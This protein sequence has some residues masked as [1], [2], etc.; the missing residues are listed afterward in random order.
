MAVGYLVPS[1]DYV[2][3]SAPFVATDG[4]APS[5][6]M[7]SSVNDLVKYAGFHLNTQSHVILSR[8]SLREMH[9][10]H[11]LYKD[12]QGGYGL[13]IA[14]VRIND[15]TVSGH[16]GGYKGYLT[17]FM[18]CRD[19]N[20][21]VIV[22]TNSVDSDPF[23]FVERAYKMVLPE[24]VKIDK[25]ETPEPPAVWQN[26]VGC[27]YSD[28]GEIEVFIRENKLQMMTIRYVHVP[29]IMLVPT[30]H[31]NEFVIK[32]P[33]NPQETARFDLDSEGR[34]KRMW[35]RNEYLLPKHLG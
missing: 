30:D 22:L 12:W 11:W 7:S 18:M 33:N 19:H 20:F 13:G 26:F 29:P 1:V 34:V 9:N 3:K 28:S 14:I 31:P 25:P 24:V 35:M 8:H 16:S 6:S 17:Q 32:D 10:V 4:F 5:A 2:H 23:Q 15:W 21:G 27:Y